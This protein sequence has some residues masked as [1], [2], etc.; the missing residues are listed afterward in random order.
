MGIVARSSGVGSSVALSAGLDPDE[1]VLEG[2]A[3]VGGGADAEAG[4]DDVAPVAPGE[5]GGG[6]DAVAG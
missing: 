2:V 1:G 6:L 5:L 3:G 4:A